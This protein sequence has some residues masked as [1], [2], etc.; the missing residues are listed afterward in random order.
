VV[1][2]GRKSLPPPLT[3][4][5]TRFVSVERIS[6]V[7]RKTKRKKESFGMIITSTLTLGGHF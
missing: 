6:K 3:T 7:M 5:T 4:T 1:Q 2:K